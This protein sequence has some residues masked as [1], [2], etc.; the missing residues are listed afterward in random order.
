MT[1][2]ALSRG[3]D[4]IERAFPGSV[5]AVYLFGSE[6]RGD[7]APGSDVDLG[8]LLAATPARTIEGRAL[9][10][11]DELTVELGREA[12]V[13]VL[14]D[15]PVDLVARVLRDGKLLL[16]R[17]RSARIR[18]EVRVRNEYFDL[19]PYLRRYRSAVLARAAA[20]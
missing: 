14:N 20:T 7:A 4:R 11:A 8:I 6:A 1:P 18:F 13:V 9:D 17:D 16:D 12:D 15:A 3:L 10:L 5:V 2:E 19:L